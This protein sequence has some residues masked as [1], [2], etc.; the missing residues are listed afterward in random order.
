M[1][2]M[3]CVLL[4]AGAV[5][6]LSSP[7]AGDSERAQAVSPGSPTAS[8]PLSESCPT[9]SWGAVVDAGGYELVIYRVVAN[10]ELETTQ[11]VEVPRGATSWTPSGAQCPGAGPGSDSGARYAWAVRALSP[12]GA[13]PWSQALLFETP[14]RPTEDEV[15]QAL[16]VLGR[17]QEAS[18]E[19]RPGKAV[20]HREA[21]AQVIDGARGEGSAAW[22]SQK[23][24]RPLGG[25]QV[26]GASPRDLLPEALSAST[27][28][29]APS[30][31]TVTT[32]A[33]FSLDIDG[34]FNLGGFV[35]QNGVPFIH[36]DGGE[37]YRN[38]AVGLNALV[39]NTTGYRNTATGG[40]ALRFNTEGF[41]NTA[42]GDKALW[43]CPGS[44]D[45][46]WL[47]ELS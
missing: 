43:R 26:R 1:R 20:A 2:W 23:A 25:S 11:Q 17:Y 37:A 32:P 44:V 10:G 28:G 35:F 15:R 27:V 40:S 31:R 21:A 19:G 39:S 14:G 42:N 9:F 34:D 41:R 24:R 33:S 3:P 16:R 5:C 30:L 12:A 36:N 38:T 45:S 47:S 29:V 6:L 7:V 18:L 4:T 46:L 22:R 8:R 13:G